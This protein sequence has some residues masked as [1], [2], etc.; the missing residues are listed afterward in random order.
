MEHKKIPTPKDLY[1]LGLAELNG[2]YF[3][4]SC[5]IK[6]KPELAYSHK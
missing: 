2:C 1:D 4:V 6:Q 5:E 3:R